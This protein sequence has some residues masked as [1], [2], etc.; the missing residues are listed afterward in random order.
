MFSCMFFGNVLKEDDDSMEGMFVIK[1]W[2][3]LSSLQM[4]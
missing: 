1:P 3:E 2:I 4:T